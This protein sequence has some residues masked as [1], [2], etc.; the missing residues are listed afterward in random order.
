[1]KKSITFIL[2]IVASFLFSFKAIGQITATVTP[3][4]STCQ[5]NGQITITNAQGGAAPYEYA[6]IAGPGVPTP[7]NYQTGNQFIGLQAGNFTVS[8]VDAN[9]DEKTY[10]TTVT[11]TYVIPNYTPV[12][13][14]NTCASG[15]Q[16]GKITFTNITGGTAPYQTRI[17]QPTAQATAFV[18][19]K[20]VYDNLPAGLSYEVQLIDACQNFQ[21]RQVLMPQISYPVL[22]NA[23]I[24]KTACTIYSVDFTTSGGKT[25]YTYKVIAPSD[26]SIG[27]TS[28]TGHFDLPINKSYTVEVTDACG[29]K[30][31]KAFSVNEITYLDAQTWG[32]GGTSCNGA[33]GNVAIGGAVHIAVYGGLPPFTGTITSTNCTY[34]HTLNLNNVGGYYAEWSIN[35]LPRPCHFQY[36]ITDACGTTQTEEFDMIGPG[37]A[38]DTNLDSGYEIKCP[39]MSVNL[40][41]M[42]YRL[43]AAAWYGPP[44]SPVGPFSLTV[45][46]AN[47]NHIAGSP[48][49]QNSNEF[50][51]PLTGGT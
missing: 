41:D 8:I 29:F 24:T 38:N 15:Q 34:T 25:P 31:T 44:Y 12:P 50:W 19:G 21:T 43:H 33:T 40:N 32:T 6:L 39:D 14:L 37:G 20:L 47:G 26:G 36:T 28:T 30:S 35:D 45:K 7:A 46:D 10:T 48:F 4:A 2:L 11:S 49:S 5:A 42:R 1:M 13:T 22:S 51:V 18:T 9:G 3:T 17:T 16:D 23:T 27:T